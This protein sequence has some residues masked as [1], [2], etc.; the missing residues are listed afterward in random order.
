MK[1]IFVAAF[2]LMA[3]GVQA[4]AASVTVV[5][6]GHAATNFDSLVLAVATPYNV[7]VILGQARL[8]NDTIKMDLDG[9][10]TG[11]CTIY[12]PKGVVVTCQSNKK[13]WSFE[14]IMAAPSVRIGSAQSFAMSG[15][16]QN[17]KLRVDLSTLL[18]QTGACFVTGP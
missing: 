13:T 14:A 10:I 16:L 4:G 5:C 1:K 6:P 7:P 2:L 12:S 15:R 17:D 11:T 3:F 8:Q 18:P 9:I